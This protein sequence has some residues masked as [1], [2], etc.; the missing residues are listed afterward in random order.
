MKVAFLVI[1]L[2]P[3]GIGLYIVDGNVLLGVMF[4]AAAGFLLW[5]SAS[6]VGTRTYVC[7]VC[8]T[9]SC[10]SGADEECYK[11]GAEV[12]KPFVPKGKG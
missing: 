7:S 3:G 4:L 6:W 2:I 8:G 5:L 9:E 1:A 12:G 10:L 11:C